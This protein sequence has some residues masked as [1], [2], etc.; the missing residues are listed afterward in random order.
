MTGYPMVDAGMRQ[1]IATGWMHNRLRLI[2]ASFLV[3][4]LGIDWRRGESAF[5]EHLLD[6]D[7]SQNNGN[8]QWVA[9]VGTDAAPYFRVFNPVVQGR[10]FDPQGTFVRRWLP[11]LE[12]VPDAWV[13][14]PWLATAGRRAR[15]YPEPIVDHAAARARSLDRYAAARA[16]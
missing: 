15:A 5:M 9:G 10:R 1:L 7:L 8:W 6:G 16:G 11:E 14:E 2:T 3:K 12:G 4:D 13:H